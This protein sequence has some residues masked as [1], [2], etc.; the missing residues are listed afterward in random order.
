MRRRRHSKKERDTEGGIKCHGHRRCLSAQ[1]PRGKIA[2]CD[3]NHRRQ[4]IKR[5]DREILGPWTNDQ[6]N[7]EKP[8]KNGRQSSPADRLPKEHCRRQ[9]DRQRQGLHDRADIGD[10]HVEQC[11]QEKIG[12]GR[13]RN[14][15][16]QHKPTVLTRNRKTQAPHC[17]HHKRNQAGCQNAPQHQNLKQRQLCRN[18]LHKCVIERKRRHRRHHQDSPA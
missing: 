11:S 10:W 7:P 13:L 4:S 5:I 16:R 9:C 6:H 12:R 8:D 17:E 2:D 1:A 15:T 3:D 18:H 14:N